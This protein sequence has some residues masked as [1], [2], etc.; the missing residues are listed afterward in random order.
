MGGGNHDTA[1]E[2]GETVVWWG[3]GGVACLGCGK[4]RLDGAGSRG[5]VIEVVGDLPLDYGRAGARTRIAEAS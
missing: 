4:R 1:V 2:A 3:G 5:V